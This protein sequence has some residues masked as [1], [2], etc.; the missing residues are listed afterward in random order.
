MAVVMLQQETS[1]WD[2]MPGELYR[3]VLRVRRSYAAV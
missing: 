1:V 2:F 3:Q